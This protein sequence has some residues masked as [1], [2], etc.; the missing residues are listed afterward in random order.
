MENY[1]I[2][3][4]NIDGESNFYMSETLDLRYMD[5]KNITFI[6][7][8]YEIINI[9]HNVLSSLP[10]LS[11]NIKS[12]DISSNNFYRL[13]NNFPNSLR[14]LDMTS[15]HLT[16]INNKVSFNSIYLGYNR[17][18]RIDKSI[19]TEL[20]SSYGFLNNNQLTFD[21]FIGDFCSDNNPIHHDQSDLIVSL[22]IIH[23][24][25][26]PL[27]RL[28]KQDHFLR[29]WNINFLFLLTKK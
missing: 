26:I 19:I 6:P 9:R 28:I 25:L 1:Q 23:N 10:T 27:S 3:Y 12:L 29:P 4:T 14:Y 22:V 21:N 20:S 8:Q 7:Q 18:T 24:I 13:P 15:N 16:F 17:I 11:N 5:I 2:K